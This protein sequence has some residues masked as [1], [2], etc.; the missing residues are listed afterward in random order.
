MSGAHVADFLTERFATVPDNIAFIDDSQ[1]YTYQWILDRTP[2]YEELL[3]ESGIQPGNVVVVLAE[4]SPQVFCL[5]LA[6]IKRG[7]I[8]APMTR[9]SVVEKDV[10]VELSECQWLIE[11]DR[12][13]RRI[14]VERI[15]RVHTSELLKDFRRSGHPGLLLF[16]SG[17]TGRPKGM[18]MD[19]A[20]VLAKFHKPR[21]AI[22]AISFL[23]LDHFGGINTL[24]HITSSLGTVVTIKQRTVSD[25]CQAIQDYKV[26]VL[27]ATPSFLN[28]LVH[29]DPMASYDLTS[30]KVISYGTEVMP[31][32]TLDRLHRLFPGVRIQQTYGLSEVGV[33]R[34]QSRPDGS[35]WVKIGGERFRPK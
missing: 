16:S 13:P 2:E 8:I 27:P 31:Q 19:F 29:S 25:I 32:P 7:I 18:L 20:T 11:F 28:I 9:D 30:L 17:S 23:M 21:P 3:K 4:Y 34:S 24:F 15:E 10:V 35:L 5:I 33:L 22:V 6:G 12:D 14:V 1:E 26:E